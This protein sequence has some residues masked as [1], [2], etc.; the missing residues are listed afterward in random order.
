MEHAGSVHS[1]GMLERE[2]SSLLG[3]VSAEAAALGRSRERTVSAALAHVVLMV[4]VKR[5]LDPDS[6]CAACGFHADDLADRDRQV[7][8]A[9]LAALLRALVTCVPDDNIA[10]DVGE[11]AVLEQFGY[12]GHALKHASTPLEALTGLVKYG[13]LLDSALQLHGLALERHGDLLHVILPDVS[14]EK[15]DWAEALLAGV[16][17]VVRAVCPCE[18]K[19]R[20]V[21]FARMTVSLY[22]QLYAFFDAPITCARQ[23]NR[24]LL[25]L[26]PLELPSKHADA[27][28]ARHFSAQV[29][30]LLEQHDDPFVTLVYRAIATQLM[31]GDL[32]QERVGRYLALSSR[33]L[34][35]KLSHHGLTYS[36]LVHETRKSVAARLLLDPE[37][38]VSE[39]ANTL[40]FLDVCSFGR[41]FKRWTG[42]SPRVYR[43][44]QRALK[45]A[46]GW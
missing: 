43:D 14:T 33:S 8:Y 3:A 20:E 38:S 10:A 35:R 18:I 4:G 24:L 22:S 23:D 40:W 11:T 44:K 26:A 15:P 12:L 1:P 29:D 46:A 41:V 25:E 32:S 9:W 5:G 19:P 37:R 34:Q 30:K 27:N 28:S 6:V 13:R 7:P 39:V 17:G 2:S 36:T 45:Q 31:Q 42:L 21:Q 16:L